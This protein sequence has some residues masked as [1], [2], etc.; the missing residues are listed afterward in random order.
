MRKWSALIILSMA[1]FIIVIDT[2]I[3]NVSISALVEDLGTTVG[4][5]QA[6]ISIYALVMASFML[7]G[8]KLGGIFGVKR[9]FIAGVACFGI[10]TGIASFSQSLGMLIIGWSVIEGLGSALM[11]PNIQTLLRKTYD[12]ED[13]AYAYGIIS[14]VA[15]VGMAVG[16]IAGGLLT[17]Y[18]SWRWAFRLEVLIVVI[19]L[20][21]HGQTKRDTLPEQR[22]GFDF[23]GAAISIFGWASI[24]LGTLLIGEYGLFEA[25]KP[26]VIGS[27][28]IA[29]L[30]LSVAPFIIGLGLLLVLGL[31]RWERR[32]EDKGGDGLFKPSLFSIPGLSSGFAVRFVSLFVT[33]AFMFTFPLLLQL[34]FEYSAIETGLTLMPFSI[35]LLITAIVGAR[36]SS[37]FKA[38]RIIQVGFLAVIAGLVLMESTINPGLQPSDLASG[39]V[40]G[41]GLGLIASQILNLIFSSVDAEDTPETTGLNGTFEQLGNAMGVAL[42]GVIML[43]SLTTGIQKG[44]EESTFI[45]ENQQDAV[46]QPVESGIELVSDSQLNSGLEASGVDEA[47]RTEILGIYSISRTDAFKGGIAFLLFVSVAGLI[48]TTGLSNRKLVEDAQ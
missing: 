44:V 13:R 3:M 1:M 15:A 33:A 39:A 23:I 36:L 17:T 45:P 28:E 8:G 2:T 19:V 46:V 30:G 6:A 16:P 5:V 22:P 10:G 26:L 35:A 31:F 24:V 47:T 11:M 25:K 29:P 9:T 41:A 21:L 40:F 32:L 12:S 34:T 48:I 37:R 18:A 42:V 20:V 43:A 27:W 38:K 14:A 4:G 7:I